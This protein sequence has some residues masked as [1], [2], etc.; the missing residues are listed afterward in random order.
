M[1]DNYHTVYHNYLVCFGKSL[2]M[3]LEPI[4]LA[5]ICVGTPDLASTDK[6][7]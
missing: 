1:K 2:F 4:I 3:S 6:K 5:L 7:K